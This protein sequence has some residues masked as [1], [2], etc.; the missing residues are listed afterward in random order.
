MANYNNQNNED[1]RGWEPIINSFQEKIE[2]GRKYH[3]EVQQLRQGFDDIKSAEDYS[4]LVDQTIDLQN[5]IS[6]FLE[7][8]KSLEE[9]NALDL[10]KALQRNSSLSFFPELMH[11]NE[12]AKQNILTAKE[13][14][15]LNELASSLPEEKK[16]KAIA[17]I[18]EVKG[19]KNTA[20]LI[21]LQVNQLKE[22][23]RHA[24]EEQLNLL[25]Y[26]ISK[27]SNSLHAVIEG[28]SYPEDEE[29]AR[30]INKYLDQTPHI[31][32]ILLAFNFEERLEN[33]LLRAR[34]AAAG[35]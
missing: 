10:E 14:L 27:I 3:L 8:I 9:A 34:A 5:K 35:P 17:F 21:N 4:R 22:Q 19:L 20:D 28:L 29:I 16:R 32:G 23:I 24:P 1:S 26:S 12:T 6:R 11:F 31:K 18:N 7:P 33:E 15:N 25:D 2:E 30:A 13:R